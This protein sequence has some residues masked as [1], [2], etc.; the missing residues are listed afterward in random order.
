LAALPLASSSLSASDGSAIFSS[1]FGGSGAAAAGSGVGAGIEGSGVTVGC[2]VLVVVVVSGTTA[3]A[4]S[5]PLASRVIKIAANAAAATNAKP[6]R[7]ASGTAAL[8]L[9][10]GVDTGARLST[11]LNA[12]V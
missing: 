6:P 3:T 4:A 7:I 1:T 11:R 2:A 10:V 9:V 12:P 8:L 5:G